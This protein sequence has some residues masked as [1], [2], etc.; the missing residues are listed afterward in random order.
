[1]HVC[2]KAICREDA[3]NSWIIFV[4][5]REQCRVIYVK[6]TFMPWFGRLIDPMEIDAVEKKIIQ[7][8][9]FIEPQELYRKEEKKIGYPR[10][11]CTFQQLKLI[12]CVWT[13]SRKITKQM[14]S[15]WCDLMNNGSQ[16]N[17]AC[18]WWTYAVRLIHVVFTRT[19][20]AIPWI[21]GKVN[22]SLARIRTMENTI[23]S[24]TV[25][26]WARD[27]ISDCFWNWKSVCRIH[28]LIVNLFSFVWASNRMRPL[29]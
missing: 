14:Q 1:M 13:E 24:K 16:L 18:D 5:R 26:K 9:L 8:Q 3:G 19:K 12:W 27:W 21:T 23:P 25:H 10:R 22:I 2:G 17:I 7:K 28:S 29:N 4:F 20:F 6:A 11:I 15:K